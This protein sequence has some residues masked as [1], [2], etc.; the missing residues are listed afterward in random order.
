MELKKTQRGFSKIEFKDRYGVSCSLQKSSL[1]DE[2][3]I[4]LGVDQI[5]PEILHEGKWIPYPIP[6]DVFLSSRMHLT[7]EQVKDLLPY[8][9][10]FAE[11]G[12]LSS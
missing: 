2:D 3:C 4:W 12:E 6:T 1:A 5:K 9:L 10:H 7:Q 11:K 8:L